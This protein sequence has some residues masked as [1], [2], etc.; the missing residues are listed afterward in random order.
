MRRVKRIVDGAPKTFVEVEIASSGEFPVGNETWVIQ[1]GKKEFFAGWIP[2]NPHRLSCIMTPEEFAQLKDGDLVRVNLGFDA[3]R[4]G[5]A[6]KS[7]ARLDKS[8]I[9]KQK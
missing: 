4:A 5:H 6:G 2:Q 3:L 7:F 9:D 8:M 1:I